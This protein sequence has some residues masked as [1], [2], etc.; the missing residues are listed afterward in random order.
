MPRTGRTHPSN[1]DVE[2]HCPGRTNTSP[3]SRSALAVADRFT[4]TRLTGS[5]TSRVRLCVC[6]P[7]IRARWPEGRTS[8]SCPTAIEPPVSVPV[9]TVPAPRMVN[10]R[11]MNWR[12]LASRPGRGARATRSSSAARSSSIPSSLAA[13]HATIG[14]PSSRVPSSFPS[15][16]LARPASAFSST[17]SSLVR[18]TTAPLAPSTSTIWRCS[19]DWGFHPSSA[20]TTN[21]TSRTGPTPAS[22]FLTNRS[23]PGTSTNPI[24]WPD[25]SVVQANPRSIVRPRRF[26]SASLS[27]SIPVRRRISA[28]LPWSTWP[29]VATTWRG[30]CS[31]GADEGAAVMAASRSGLLEDVADGPCQPVVVLR[32]HGAKVEH[33]S[34]VV[35]T[36]E[37][38][39]AAETKLGCRIVRRWNPDHE[40]R[41]R[42]A[43]PG[44]RTSAGDRFPLPSR[45]SLEARRQCLRPGQEPPLADREEVPQRK[46]VASTGGVQAKD[47]L[48]GGDGHLVDSEG[49]SDGMAPET[50][51][52]VCPSGQE[53]G[54]GATEQLVA[55]KRDQI[56]PTRQRFGDRRFLSGDLGVAIEQAAS[57]VVQQR[58]LRFMGEPAQ[59]THRNH[60]GE[61]HHPIV[62][63]MDLQDQRGLRVDGPVIV[64]SARAIRGPNLDQLRPGSGHD[65]GQAK[66]STDL[67][68]LSPRDQDFLLLRQCC[69]GQ[70]Q[71]SRVVVHNQRILRSGERDEESLRVGGAASPRARLPFH[72]EVRVGPPGQRGGVGRPLRE[73]RASQPRVQDHSGCIDDLGHAVEAPRSQSERV[74]ED[75]VAIGN[76]TPPRGFRTDP[77]QG[78]LKHVLHQR[79]AELERCLFSRCSAKEGVERGNAAPRVFGPELSSAH[80][81]GL[82]QGTKRWWNKGSRYNGSHF[83]ITPECSSSCSH[84]R[85]CSTSSHS[86]TTRYTAGSTS[87]GPI[88]AHRYPGCRLASSSHRMHVFLE[89]LAVRLPSEREPQVGENRHAVERSSG[90]PG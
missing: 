75:L 37:H 22:M 10:T 15:I 11:S 27:G 46:L 4:A 5:A 2:R 60:I 26:S 14:A 84:A 81:A 31:R 70:E 63:R 72:L 56:G 1:T 49:S 58:D 90:I 66:L 51:D 61:S 53:A 35:H 82:C 20:A 45:R 48:Q 32:R 36:A 34:T 42:D 33:E 68:Q 43:V 78:G 62:A 29:A 87:D 30:R 67:D 89:V 88:S 65:L 39:R 50:L 19:S 69:Q 41:R 47:C 40:F 21:S 7:R 13:E 55:G 24:S 54:L 74:G 86:E 71:R 9:T 17:R 83:S 79:P 57:H 76:G 28:D 52:Q 23:C 59:F 73:R 8:A 18:A 3:R 12:G 77:R 25:G 85:T 38:G 44:E 64:V 16:C 6:S 80:G